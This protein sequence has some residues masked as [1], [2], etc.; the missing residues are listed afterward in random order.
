M[1]NN[2]IHS[3]LS[4]AAIFG[5]IL[6]GCYLAMIFGVEKLSQIGLCIAG[7]WACIA[8]ILKTIEGMFTACSRKSKNKSEGTTTQNLKIINRG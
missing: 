3:L 7:V 6:Y 1:I 5:G 4:V 2:L 8:L